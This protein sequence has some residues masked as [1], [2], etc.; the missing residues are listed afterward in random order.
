MSVRPRGLDPMMTAA[1]VASALIG[2]QYI[3]GKAAR[4][5]LFLAAFD[6]TMLPRMI[7]GTSLFSI[8]LV[9][10]SGWLLR[11]VQ[12]ST[13]VPAAFALSAL[14]L[15]GEWSLT[16][17]GPGVAASLL[18]LQVSGL[19]PML[20]SGF[21][22]MASER[23][24][25]RSARRLFG[26]IAGAGTVGGLLAGLGAARIV[27]ATSV[28]TL[29]PLLAVMNA[30]CAWQVWSIGRRPITAA[31]RP[32]ESGDD[33]ADAASG[34]RV[35]AGA[36]YLRNLAVLVLLGTIA[37]VLVDYV[38]KVEVKTAYGRGPALG[39]FFSIYYA[40]VSLL[41]FGVQTLASKVALERLGLAT[42]AA[43]PAMSL[44]AG[45]AL[46]LAVPGMPALVLA[47]GAEA[48][49]R[50]SLF[51]A[52]YELFYTPMAPADK[53]AVKAVID[54]G[55]DRSGDIVGATIV[56]GLLLLPAARQPT[57]MIALGVLCSVGALAVSR[58]LT[59]G[60]VAT[61]EQNLRNRAVD[62]DLAEIIDGTTRTVML[63][64]LQLPGAQSE[65]QAGG[66]D[67]DRELL[68]IAALRSRDPVRAA[69]VMRERELAP[70]LVAHVIPL[71]EDDDLLPD[72]LRAL[73]AVADRHVGELT[74][75]L[76]DQ[77]RPF[78]V[79]RRLA[80]AFSVCGSQRAADG[81]LLGLDDLRF[82]VRAQC[83]RSL[84]VM[85]AK[86]P[87]LTI[88]R[89]RVFGVVNREVGVSRPVWEGRQLLDGAIDVDDAS[90]QLHAAVSR[91]ASHAL[92]HVFTLLSLVLP[93]EPV[94]IAYAGLQTTDK[95]LRGTALEYLDA[96]LPADIRNGL[97]PF[98]DVSADRP[99]SSRSRDE[100]V[101]ELMN[102]N[103]S[104]QLH[105][106]AMQKAAGSAS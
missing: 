34:L 50:G 67:A 93:A 2:A 53:R 43:T 86:H 71:L 47:R 78:A 96:T 106:A 82:E 49:S 37:A 8:M 97:W 101:A 41:T 64:T 74:D 72:A 6:A 68:A 14:L 27:S 13:W 62:L 4:D 26:M 84:A 88:D 39:S 77:A 15:F 11:R 83:A 58:R 30:I 95:G 35:L 69:R 104:I 90:A 21:W 33:M 7:I 59:A 103:Q 18:Y 70:P 65:L 10:A 51:R 31:A 16:S 66:A 54:V 91:R 28:E 94:R 38:F 102:A 9:V 23:F 25:P 81:L 61:L 100:I 44:A 46:S 1:V 52:G 48:V 98:L 5:A 12:P 92:T 22:L 89:A 73:R 24:D 19:G 36:S 3:A 20:G 63:R 99:R 85:F 57:A 32:S 56:Q 17:A 60:Y 42:C 80:R 29:L 55:V 76:L 79:R 45:G 40:A 105:L 75:A 87:A